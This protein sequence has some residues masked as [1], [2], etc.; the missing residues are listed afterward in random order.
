[1]TSPDDQPVNNMQTSPPMP[2]VSPQLRDLT[3]DAHPS[4]AHLGSKQSDEQLRIPVVLPSR[5]K[6]HREGLKLKNLVQH[7]S[8]FFLGTTLATK[9]REKSPTALETH[10]LGNAAPTSMSTGDVSLT[11]PPLPAEPPKSPR[12]DSAEQFTNLPAPPAPH[13]PFEVLVNRLSSDEKSKYKPTPF[14]APSCS[15]TPFD[16]NE[17]SGPD[18]DDDYVPDSQ[19]TE[20]G[21]THES[22]DGDTEEE[23]GPGSESD[24]GRDGDEDDER[25]HGSDEDEDEDEDDAVL[26]G[27]KT[28]QERREG[29][30][31]INVPTAWTW[32]REENDKRVKEWKLEKAI[33]DNPTTLH[34]VRTEWMYEARLNGE[35]CVRFRRRLVLNS[36]LFRLFGGRLREHATL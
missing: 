17:E 13:M 6:D 23:A 16:D 7:E 26:E 24:D 19:E 5:S 4:L 12:P 2:L 10:P 33:D 32:S 25:C 28:P 8:S 31:E 20:D 21:E 34:P 9:P 14:A 35:A 22:G 11:Y 27:G 18:T 29:I 15:P 1:M 3:P 36:P 30:A